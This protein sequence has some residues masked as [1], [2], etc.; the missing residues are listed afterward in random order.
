M[1]EH[2]RDEAVKG[3]A[4]LCWVLGVNPHLLHMHL[5]GYV[6]FMCYITLI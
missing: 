6:S 1:A 4:A 5:N 2:G 3:S